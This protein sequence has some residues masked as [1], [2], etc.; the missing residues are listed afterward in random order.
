MLFATPPGF[1]P[2][3]KGV[4][5]LGD[6]NVN[7]VLR[8]EPGNYFLYNS[9]TPSPSTKGQIIV[10]DLM[11]RN[12]TTF[13]T[14]F[15]IEKGFRVGKLRPV[16]FFE[17]TNLFNGKRPVQISRFSKYQDIPKFGLPYPA[18][19]PVQIRDNN[20]IWDQYSSFPNRT[21]EVY[22]GLRLSM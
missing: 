4:N 1:G 5:L 14:D 17:A 11:F 15:G 19:T 7:L 2:A 16:V 13:T 10:N 22:F 3:F 20:A 9:P 8:V 12:F 6:V 18:P 21:R